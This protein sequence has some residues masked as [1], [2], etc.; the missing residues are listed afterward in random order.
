[1]KSKE[2]GVFAWIIERDEYDQNTQFKILKNK[3][4]LKMIHIF[5]T[6]L[7]QGRNK[8]DNQFGGQ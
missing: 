5:S 3:K 8:S 1:L 4:N 7:H 6:T 2:P